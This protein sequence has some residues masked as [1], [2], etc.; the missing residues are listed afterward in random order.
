MVEPVG[1]LLI[2]CCAAPEGD[3]RVALQA[4][5]TDEWQDLINLAYR[6][7]TLPLLARLAEKID[8]GGPI[9]TQL[10]DCAREAVM[11]TLAQG[12]AISRVVALLHERGFRPIAL[13]GLA[14]AHRDYPDPSLRPL[15]DIDL[16]VPRDEV[17][18]AQKL[19]LS[20]PRFTYLA[21]AGRYGVEY[22][23]QLP[24]LVD[25]ESGLVIELHHR[26]NARGWDGEVHLLDLITRSTAHADILGV[27]VHVP[28]AHTNFL[29]LVEHATWHHLFSNGPVL[30]A[31]LHFLA[32]GGEQIDW[33]RLR[34][35]AECMGLGCALHLVA[36]M[37]RQAGASWVPDELITSAGPQPELVETA[38]VALLESDE[39]GRQH[40]MLQRVAG[41]GG[42]VGALHALRQALRP[43]PYQLA[44]LA[45]CDV[46]D[47][48]R[49]L[50]YP[51]W[52][53]EKGGRY[54]R[55]M[56][57]TEIRAVSDDRARLKQ[58]IMQG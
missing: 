47:P 51:K 52:L 55:T 20:Q 8:L 12:R 22:G 15:R 31:D 39:A 13:K 2:A 53:V 14:L 46:T 17:E 41:R 19:L 48:M 32:T 30:L 49:W 58:W 56:Q 57:N 33:P 18:E 1:R 3:H 27:P 37:A 50:G 9:A 42:G 45:G 5:A 28:S 7:R 29:H 34:A 10:R 16:L 26:L 24:E 25:L 54:L 40:A 38:Y 35:D 23:H 44:R 6:T 11:H 21:A 36:A 4:L 43:D